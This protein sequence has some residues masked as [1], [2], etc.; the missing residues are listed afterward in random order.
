MTPAKIRKQ[1]NAAKRAVINAETYY[2]S[3]SSRDEVGK[4]AALKLAVSARFKLDDLKS[5]M[6]EYTRNQNSLYAKFA[7]K[8]TA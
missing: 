7:P 8:A 3:I 5:L 4:E 2:Y 1:I 6:S